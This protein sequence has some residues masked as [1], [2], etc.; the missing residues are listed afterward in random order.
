MPAG[1]LEI[2]VPSVSEGFVCGESLIL[3]G[4]SPEQAQQKVGAETCSAPLQPKSLC[5]SVIPLH[6]SFSKRNTFK[7]ESQRINRFGFVLLL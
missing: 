2:H 7:L 5:N 1:Y 3:T 4:Q 6:C